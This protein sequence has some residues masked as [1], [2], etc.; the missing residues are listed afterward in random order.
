MSLPKTTQEPDDPQ[1]LPPARRRR[2][3]RLL[4]PLDADEREGFFLFLA[5]RSAPTFDFFLFSLIGGLIIA[6]ALATDQ[7]ALLLLGVLMAPLMAP[8]VGLLLGVTIGSGRLFWESVIGIGVGAAFVFVAGM[9]AGLLPGNLLPAPESVYFLA[10]IHGRLSIIH[11]L[12][13]TIGAFLMT[14]RL[15]REKRNAHIPSAAV[16]YA[17][18]TPLA[19]AGF[20]LVA[21]VPFL[22]P[23]GL[24]VFAL[25]FSLAILVSAATL[26]ALGYRPP[27][28]LGYTVG[29]HPD[30]FH[31]A[32]HHPFPDPDAYP[33]AHPHPDA[34]APHADSNTSGGSCFC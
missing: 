32:F 6:L 29:G 15:A 4:I 30:A 3:R 25:S 21:G 13:L 26:L 34:G 5:R 19:T 31:Y 9:A 22:F 8:V 20:G 24:V 17:L 10:R 16:A 27:T 14:H 33:N 11:F 1:N 12:V 18:Y 23:D 28:S 7:P 2:A